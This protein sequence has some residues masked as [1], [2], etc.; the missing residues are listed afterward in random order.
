MI[1]IPHD[2]ERIDCNDDGSLD[3]VA[4]SIG[5]GMFRLEQMDKGV[6]WMALY[7]PDGRTHTFHFNAKRRIRVLHEETGP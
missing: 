6:W 7:M 2:V 5:G 3:D 1:S 4:I